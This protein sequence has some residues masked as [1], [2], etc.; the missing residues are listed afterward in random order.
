M[1][2]KGNY[3]DDFKAYCKNAVANQGVSLTGSVLHG[4][5]SLFIDLHNEDVAEMFM[6]AGQL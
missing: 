6:G 3:S 5:H 4:T 2:Y 1:D